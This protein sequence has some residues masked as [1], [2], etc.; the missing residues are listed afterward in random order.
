MYIYILGPNL[1]TM[2]YLDLEV[3]VDFRTGAKF[4]NYGLPRS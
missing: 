1:K 2:D 4:K 3:C